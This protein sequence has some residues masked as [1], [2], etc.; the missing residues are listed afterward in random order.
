MGAIEDDDSQTAEL[1]LMEGLDPNS[2]HNNADIAW[3]NNNTLLHW[4]ARLSAA[5]CAK[6]QGNDS[7]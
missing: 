1:I 5:K 6:V 3:L 4:T 2:R 7:P